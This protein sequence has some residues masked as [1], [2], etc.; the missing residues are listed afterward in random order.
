MWLFCHYLHQKIT[1]NV[2]SAGRFCTNTWCLMYASFSTC[3][4]FIRNISENTVKKTPPNFFIKFSETKDYIVFVHNLCFLESPDHIMK[5][6]AGYL[7]YWMIKQYF[8]FWHFLQKKIIFSKNK[9]KVKFNWI[10][11]ARPIL[12]I[13]SPKIH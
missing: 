7:F 13:F 12:P 3:R 5:L 11:T 10:I 4:R 1:C 8:N 6:W 9:N 2:W